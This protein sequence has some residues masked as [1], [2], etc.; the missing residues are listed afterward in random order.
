LI[1]RHGFENQMRLSAKIDAFADAL[2]LSGG[3]VGEGFMELA[4]TLSPSGDL[5]GEMADPTEAASHWRHQWRR[6]PSRT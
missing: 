2:I 6:S 3:T 1:W 4:R 5:P